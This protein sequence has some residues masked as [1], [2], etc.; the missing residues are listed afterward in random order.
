MI[1]NQFVMSQ[2]SKVFCICSIFLQFGQNQTKECVQK[3]IW[4]SRETD[5]YDFRLYFDILLIIIV[6]II[7]WVVVK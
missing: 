4:I 1:V 6:F 2:D 3:L 7:T 5:H